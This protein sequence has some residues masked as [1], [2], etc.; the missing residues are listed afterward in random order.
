[1]PKYAHPVLVC[2]ALL[3]A[4]CDP[5][6]IGPSLIPA[7]TERV[8]AAVSYP[9]SPGGGNSLVANGDS[10]YVLDPQG[11]QSARLSL[12]SS[13]GPGSYHEWPRA[14]SSAAGDCFL[15][16]ADGTACGLNADGSLRWTLEEKLLGS[17]AV[18]LSDGLLV[19][20]SSADTYALAKLHPDGTLGWRQSVL[21]SDRFFTRPYG[22][23]MAAMLE[24]Q[25]L[26]LDGEGSELLR[27]DTTELGYQPSLCIP[28][29]D[30]FIL[31]TGG[32][33]VAVDLS[34]RRLWSYNSSNRHIVIGAALSNERT[35]LKYEAYPG[36]SGIVVL[37]GQGREIRS[38]SGNY[39]HD[40]TPVDAT[41]FAALF[42]SGS[43]VSVHLLSTESDEPLWRTRLG[44]FDHGGLVRRGETV[45]RY[46]NGTAL[47]LGRDQR[48]YFE[49]NS[50]LIAL[51]LDGRRLWSFKGRSYSDTFVE[52]YYPSY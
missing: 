14:Y 26:V 24:N 45:E 10:L 23:G 36:E 28:S 15:L 33:A 51:D 48:L 39:W 38:F 41:R 44:D 25:L 31:V 7:H 50:Q 3:L 16:L 18:P 4:G 9:A 2:L 27:L 40:L 6:I 21:N 20:V 42:F 47:Q 8:F 35:V 43:S 19:G 52:D 29:A 32:G 34:G 46:T 11:V 1:M 30:C 22:A 49:L 5:I 13:V 12:P 17:W 37:D